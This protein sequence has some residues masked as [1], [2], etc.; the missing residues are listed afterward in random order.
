MGTIRLVSDRI[1]IEG[2]EFYGHH[3][4]SDAERTVGHRYWVDLTVWGDFRTAGLTDN[5]EDTVSYSRVARL[6][7]EI[8]TGERFALLERLGEVIARAVLEHS[9]RITEVEVTVGKPQ[10]PAKALIA[11]ASVVLH[12]TRADLSTK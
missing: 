5:I 4:V 11:K 3:G 8:A 1:R 7:I 12:R 10:P 6:V 2:I 9:P